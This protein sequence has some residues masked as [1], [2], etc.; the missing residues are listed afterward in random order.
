MATDIAFAIGL[1]GLLGTKIPFSANFF[2]TTLAIVDDLGAVLVMAI[3][4]ATLAFP[5]PV[6]IKRQSCHFNSL[7][8]LCLYWLTPVIE[9]NSNAQWETALIASA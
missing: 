1:L 5:E 6:L 7:L 4:I 9:I 2:L 8:S 3:F